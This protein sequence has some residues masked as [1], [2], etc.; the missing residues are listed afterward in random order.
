[1]LIKAVAAANPKTVV[2]LVNGTPVDMRGWLDAAPAIVEAWYPGQEGGHAL[3]RVLFGD[4]NPSGKL[5]VTF[6]KRLEDNPSHGNYPGGGGRV[7]YAE[8][9]HVG[10]RHYDTKGVEPQFPFGHGLSYTSFEYGNLKVSPGTASKDTPVTVTVDVQN[11]GSR[12]GAEVVQLYVHD[13]ESGLPRP[14]K[15]LKAFE[16]ITLAPG[17]KKTVKFTLGRDALSFYDPDRGGWVA[18]PG[19]FEVMVGSSS[20]DIRLQGVFGLE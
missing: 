17:E 11:T 13:V 2:V 10:Y 6:P 8:G 14:L 20:R 16:K 9:I 7:D 19:E 4:V 18:E 1:E 5:P 15:E 12:P 3:A